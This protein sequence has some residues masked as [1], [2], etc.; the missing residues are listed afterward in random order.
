VGIGIEAGI[1]IWELT[2]SEPGQTPA[3]KE[4][5]SDTDVF[6][7][8]PPGVDPGRVIDLGDIDVIDLG[9]LPEDPPPS[10]GGLPD[11][12]GI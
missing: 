11:G 7:S 1:G 2:T 4:T 5:M 12:G 9:D 8:I 3:P 10:G 6:G